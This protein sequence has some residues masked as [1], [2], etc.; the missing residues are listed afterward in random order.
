[1]QIDF[2]FAIAVLILS[3]MLH[4]I[5]HG[6]AAYILGDSTA[7]YAGRLTLNPL[8]HLDL[9]GSIILPT[10]TYLAGGFILGWAKPVPFN[11]FNLKNQK[12]GPAIVAA[13]GPLAN[14]L[15]VAVFALIFRSIGQLFFL[16]VSIFKLSASICL[17]NL[18]LAV[19]NLLPVPPLDGSKLLFAFLPYRWQ[20]I[21]F[22]LERYS[23]V[24]IL[25]FLFLIWQFVLPIVMFLFKLITG[26]SF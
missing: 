4:E 9:F 14:I 22:I 7:K 6:Y 10:I 23:F 18:W 21:Q 24:F 15:I 12:W 13:A 11:P 25:L 2:I 8:K 1:M 16:P 5:S 20:K 19:F 17:L 3:V 26:L